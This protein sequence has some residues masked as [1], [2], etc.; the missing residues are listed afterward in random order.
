MYI[1]GIE[2]DLHHTVFVGLWKVLFT[3]AHQLDTKIYATTHSIDCINAFIK[4]KLSQDHISSCLVRIDSGTSG[5]VYKEFNNETL[6]AAIELN[7]DL[8]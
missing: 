3:L 8:R 2:E 1:D 5:G 7:G 4:V 6:R